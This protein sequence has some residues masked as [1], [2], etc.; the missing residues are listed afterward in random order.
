MKHRIEYLLFAG[1]ARVLRLFPLAAV[2]RIAR[3]FA[4]AVFFV[5]PIRKRLTMGQIAAA[6]PSR[7]RAWVR[8]TARASYR[9]LVTTVF[10]LM[11][12]PR[13]RGAEPETVLRMHEPDILLN[14]YRRGS[15]LILMSAHY[16]NWEWL[17]IL[18]ARILGIPF[19]VIVHPLHN[20]H[21]DRLVESY[22]TMFGNRVVP[23]HSAGREA[24]RTLRNRGVV[25]LLADQSGPGSGLFVPFFGRPAAT[26]QGPAV[27]AL[28][29]GAPIVCGFC[30]RKPDGDYEVF[31]EE[32]PTSDLH[33]ATEENVAELTRRHVEAVE[34]RIAGNPGAWLWQH[35]RW[36]H[37]PP[38][39]IGT[40]GGWS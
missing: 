18:S 40:R 37:A 25:A 15:G 11:W 16:G 4:D 34:R 39:T 21:V 9:N 19:T 35:R 27:F 31:L 30:E 33:G 14:A 17:S 24:I 7:S 2:R 36:K 29:T 22:R 13:L 10:E 28:R 8:H 26:F 12:T 3:P 23:M 1:I 38:Q 32:I 5:L 6:F 20:P